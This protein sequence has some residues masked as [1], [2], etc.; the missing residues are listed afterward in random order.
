MTPVQWCGSRRPLLLRVN[1]RPVQPAAPNAMACRCCHCQPASPASRHAPVAQLSCFCYLFVASLP[2]DVIS[3][4]PIFLSSFFPLKY[5]DTVCTKMW[6]MNGP[7]DE[8]RTK[9]W[10]GGVDA[11]NYSEGGC[12]E[13]APKQ[14]FRKSFPPSDGLL[15]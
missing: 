13:R 9:D 12:Q 5:Y 8:S 11:M 7:E 1:C 3:S 2:I 6:L 15:A 10:G 4:L 14:I